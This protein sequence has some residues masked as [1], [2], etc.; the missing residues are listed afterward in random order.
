LN[1]GDGN[2]KITGNSTKFGFALA[3]FGFMDTGDG[4]DMITGSNIDEA[5]GILDNVGTG[6]LNGGEFDG[7]MYTGDG[8]DTITGISTAKNGIGL[9]NSNTYTIDTG[10]GNDIIIGTADTGVGILN[11]GTINTGNGNDSIIA[12]GGFNGIGNVFLGNGKDYLKG[13]GSGNFNGGNGKDTLELI[14]GSY[15]VGISGTTV[16]FTKGSSIMITSEFEKLIAGS[17]TYDF[18]SLTE[19]QIISVA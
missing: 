3:N 9:S 16:N 19:G 6:L 18:T 7:F 4:N 11:E 15:T 2:D 5:D 1:T 13:F 12:E 8:N 10:N 17:R 14:S